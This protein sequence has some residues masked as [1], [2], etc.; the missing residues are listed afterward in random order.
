M[1]HGLNDQDQ[2]ELQMWKSL[3]SRALLYRVS[4][5]FAVPGGQSGL[6]LYAEGEREDG[7][8]GP[9]IAG[10]QSFVQRSGHVQT[11]EMEGTALES[12]LHKGQVAFYGSFQVP[13]EIR[14][15][16]VII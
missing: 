10:F 4:P 14:K 2:E 5:D 16:H 7:T 11:F 12:R 13:D 1:R 3:V 8:I 9:G 15:E 6:A